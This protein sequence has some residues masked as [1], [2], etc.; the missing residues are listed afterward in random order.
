MAVLWLLEEYTQNTLKYSRVRGI[1]F[2]KLFWPFMLAIYFQM[3]KIRV[4][5]KV[6]LTL[7][8]FLI[9]SKIKIY[10][11]KVIVSSWEKIMVIFVGLVLNS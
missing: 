6:L 10:T 7:G 8:K 9:I 1:Y 2:G 5:C 3:V 11:M 4:L